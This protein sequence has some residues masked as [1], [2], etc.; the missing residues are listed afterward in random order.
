M[1]TL[2][3]EVLAR[4]MRAVIPWFFYAAEIA[5]A[6]MLLFFRKSATMDTFTIRVYERKGSFG[7]AVAPLHQPALQL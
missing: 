6:K 4:G 2:V 3:S 7:T 5:A 1:C